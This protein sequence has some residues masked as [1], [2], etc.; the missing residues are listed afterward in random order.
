LPAQKATSK[1][2]FKKAPKHKARPKKQK[3]RPSTLEGRLSVRD[4]RYR[5][6]SN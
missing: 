6:I 1:S 2:N 5:S 3:S 4:L